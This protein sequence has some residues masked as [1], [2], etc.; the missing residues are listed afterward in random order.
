MYETADGAW[1]ALSVASDEEW[2]R[3]RGVLGGLGDAR[4]AEA[5]G[6]L[7]HRAEL[8]AAVGGQAR[9][10]TAAELD[11]ALT[12]EGIASSAVAV[13]AALISDP[14]LASRA[15]FSEVDHPDWGRRRLIGLPWRVVGRGPFALRPP[16]LLAPTAVAR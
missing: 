13:P 15:F 3:V 5:A 11:A 14:H 12:R 9:S 4:W 16:P 10:W 7:A 1:L 6:R 8:D 2:E